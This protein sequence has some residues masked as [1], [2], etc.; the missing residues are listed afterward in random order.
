M[1]FNATRVCTNAFAV[2][3]S[4]TTVISAFGFYVGGAGDVTVMPAYQ[5]GQPTPVAV[6][7]KAVPLGTVIWLNISK[8][9]ET[10]TAAT[11]IVAFGPV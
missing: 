11:N 9:M 4:D 10:G 7:F 8:V 2:T 5:M 1:A 3:K 6:L